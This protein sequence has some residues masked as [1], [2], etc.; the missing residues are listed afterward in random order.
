[1]LIAVAGLGPGTGVTTT[2]TVLAATWPGPEPVLV[3]DA[4]LAT[5]AG[6]AVMHGLA[7]ESANMLAP[8]FVGTPP[9]AGSDPGLHPPG[10]EATQGS[11]PETMEVAGQL[12][13]VF[14][15]CGATRPM[16]ANKPI[17][18]GADAVVVVVR[19][20]LTDPVLA[21]QLVRELTADSRRRGIVLVGRTRGSE[22][23]YLKRLQIPVLGWLPW[24]PAPAGRLVQN[25]S[26]WPRKDGLTAA[27]REVGRAI[28]T[29][30]DP[31][32]SA[33]C[34][35]ADR[36][37]RGTGGGGW[38]RNHTRRSGGAP[39]PT[40]YPLH[41][42]NVLSRTTDRVGS[43]PPS[44]R[45]GD[46]ADGGEQNTAVRDESAPI[47]SSATADAEP[48]S[49]S[50]DVALPQAGPTCARLGAARSAAT[51]AHA[52][53]VTASTER[54]LFVHSAP[55]A[56]PH[57]ACAESPPALT[58]RLFGPLRVMWRPSR[59][60]M[61]GVVPEVEIT[62]RLQRR[63]REVL[64]LLAAHP[65]GLTRPQLVEAL[66]GE[67]APQRPSNAVC[68]TLAR[69]RTAI[70]EATGG[71]VTR[72]LDVESGR[73]RL[74]QDVMGPTT[75]NFLLRWLGAVSRARSSAVRC[76]SAS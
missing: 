10:L 54:R 73:L 37:Q 59:L 4:D 33:P 28:R 18:S 64:A 34:S 36:T 12:A 49:G 72:V 53:P 65:R 3:V 29:Q 51:G 25:S 45:E 68:T 69:L 23:N 44:Y 75:R 70:A 6:P 2:T 50:Q 20:D 31:A 67:R 15:D 13:V 24:S 62:G 22:D 27:A 42:A 66:W 32:T 74:D 17:V 40:V 35:T 55:C 58:L 60:E 41:A 71:T 56:S 38:R 5:G 48:S 76:A 30:L 43:A 26:R 63:S 47:A 7:A 16:S 1:M 11:V 19:V 21:G 39:A 46:T 57:A 61:G 9:L 52:A 14:A 8:C